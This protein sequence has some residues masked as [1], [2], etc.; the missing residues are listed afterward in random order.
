M[1]LTHNTSYKTKVDDISDDTLENCSIENGALVRTSTGLY[2]GHGSSNVKI[3]P[4]LG[5]GIDRK[6]ETISAD[7]T[8]GENDHVIFVNATSDIDITLPLAATYAGKEY[9]IRTRTNSNKAVLTRSGSDK[10]DD[11]GLENTVDISGDKA[12]TVISDGVST[13]YSVNDTGQ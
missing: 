13:W 4:Q 2:M 10:I 12:R 7:K 8:L 11:G 6:V 1:A 9:I 5:G 3:Y